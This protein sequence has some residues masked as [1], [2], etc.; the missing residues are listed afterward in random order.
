MVNQY[1]CHIMVVLHENHSNDKS[2]G[3]IGTE[4]TNKAETV[5]Q[6][7]V[8]DK[9]SNVSVVRAAAC[10]NKEFEGFAFEIVEGLPHIK[11]GYSIDKKPSKTA[12]NDLHDKI[13]MV[14]LLRFLKT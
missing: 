7:A 9:N 10:R 2:R 8:D 1:N 12:L 14:Y 11:D 4:L 13:N 6:V 3:H 5:L